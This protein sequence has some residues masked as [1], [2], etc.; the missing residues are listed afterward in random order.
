MF[1]FDVSSQFPIEVQQI[2]VGGTR[3]FKAMAIESFFQYY[4]PVLIVS[5]IMKDY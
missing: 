5:I 3:C 2:T 4:K 1:G